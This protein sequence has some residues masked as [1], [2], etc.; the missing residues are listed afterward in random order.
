ML[1]AVVGAQPQGAQERLG[2]LLAVILAGRKSL[3]AGERAQEGF[4]IEIVALAIG[5]PDDL[6][7]RRGSGAAQHGQVFPGG[8][9]PP[10]RLESRLGA[11]L[12]LDAH[13]AEPLCDLN[14][15]VP[16][17][18]AE[19]VGAGVGAEGIGALQGN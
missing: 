18:V 9:A 15:P 17:E 8:G 14:P 5:V 7:E 2:R 10:V 6:G 3:R 16:E 12:P 1:A 13:V 11:D 19:I 4:R